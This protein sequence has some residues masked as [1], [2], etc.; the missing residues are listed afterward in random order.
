MVRCLK[1]LKYAALC[2]VKVINYAITGNRPNAEKFVEVGGLKYIFPMLMGRGL[3]VVIIN[4]KKAKRAT[5]EK[6]E[7]EETIMSIVG[8]LCLQLHDCKEK[9]I[10]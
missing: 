8:Q 9:V 6:Q 4:G 10:S 2:A 7:F 1:E 3:P 5:Q